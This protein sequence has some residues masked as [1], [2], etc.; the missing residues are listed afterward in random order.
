MTYSASY[1]LLTIFEISYWLFYYVAFTMVT[2]V[3]LTKIT[4]LKEKVEVIEGGE[5]MEEWK[6]SYSEQY[7]V[8]LF[9]QL[10]L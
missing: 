3:L 4:P 9:F 6:S 2:E 5:A 7:G 1:L 8:E 10:T